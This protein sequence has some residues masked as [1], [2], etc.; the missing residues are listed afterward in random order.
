MSSTEEF[1]THGPCDKIFERLWFSPKFK[2]SKCTRSTISSCSKLCMETF[3]CA[4]QDAGCLSCHKKP[5]LAEC[6]VPRTTRIKISV[7]EMHAMPVEWPCKCK[8]MQ[9]QQIDASQGIAHDFKQTHVFPVKHGVS[10][11]K[12]LNP[13]LSYPT[14]RQSS[15]TKITPRHPHLPVQKDLRLQ[16]VSLHPLKVTNNK[17][18]DPQSNRHKRCLNDLRPCW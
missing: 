6:K 8:C 11:G 14:S 1:S 2:W 16:W 18:A 9:M 12:W 10:H 17:R 5:R 13:I 15:A 7:H 4:S 3:G